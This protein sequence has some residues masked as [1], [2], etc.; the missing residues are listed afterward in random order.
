[1]GDIMRLVFMYTGQ[2]V[3]AVGMGKDLLEQYPEYEFL[4]DTVSDISQIDL[5]KICFNGPLELLTDARTSGLA[6]VTVSAMIN[7]IL[8]D[9]GIHPV[10]Y[11]GYS[12]GLYNALYGAGVID[13]ENLIRIVDYRG[14]CLKE[15]ALS[16]RSTMIGVIGLKEEMVQQIC[17]KYGNA[18]I[19]NYN[20]PGNVTVSCSRSIVNALSYAFEKQEAIKAV[21]IPVEG[22]WH[23]PFMQAAAERFSKFIKGFDFARTEN[24]IIDNDANF[25]LTDYEYHRALVKHIESP[26]H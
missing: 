5:K 8:K 22:G 2:G 16:S 14:K 26:V 10:L 9:N 21:E 24:I 1:M 6:I 7:N 12:V 23:S 19:A 13:F 18:F 15:E 20:S 11:T 25:I 4:F 17:N 3:Q